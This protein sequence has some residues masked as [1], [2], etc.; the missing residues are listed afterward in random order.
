[1][2]RS[3]KKMIMKRAGLSTAIAVGALV[4]GAG[5]AGASTH[6][7]SKDAAPSFSAAD[8]RSSTDSRSAKGGP[9][10]GHRGHRGPGGVVTAVTG[11]T[12]TVQDRAGNS[13]AFTI[14][15]STAVTR[16]RAAATLAD[17]AVGE[18]VRIVPSAP[19]S[20]TASSV[21]IELANIAGKVVS[22]SGDTVTVSNRD[23]NNST[24]VVTGSTTYSKNG[25][26]ATLADVAVG[27]FI[28]A[29]GTLDSTLTT[30]HAGTV[31]IG[32]AKFGGAPDGLAQ[33]GPGGGFVDKGHG[34]FDAMGGG[35]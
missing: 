24:V 28:F 9:V 30:L 6:T 10:G 13:T 29:E 14:D 35:Y 4:T 5:I 21:E 16:E 34:G 22:V 2:Y 3:N 27:S 23:G 19:G 33:P 31:G 12:L 32:Q 26:S 11:T 17:L 15:S 1:M 8:G 20:T 25:A 7:S 18:N